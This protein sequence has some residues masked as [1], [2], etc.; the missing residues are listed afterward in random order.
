MDNLHTQTWIQN[1]TGKKVFPLLT[2]GFTGVP[3]SLQLV[4]RMYRGCTFGGC[5]N[6]PFKVPLDCSSNVWILIIYMTA[7]WIW[8]N[9]YY[10]WSGTWVQMHKS[11]KCLSLEYSR[12]YKLAPLCACRET[13]KNSSWDF[14]FVH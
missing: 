1:C 13:Q 10:E 6:C 3:S 4:L 11:P 8:T 9:W 12:L 14:Q 7:W 2:T 5:G